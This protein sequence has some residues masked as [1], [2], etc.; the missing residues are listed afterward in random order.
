MKQHSN[1]TY[2][3]QFTDAHSDLTLLSKE[4]LICLISRYHHMY[5]K[6]SNT[7]IDESQYYLTPAEAL[8][9]IRRHLFIPDIWN[10]D[11]LKI[12]LDYEMG[13]ITREEYR[14]LMG[15]NDE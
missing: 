8:A 1:S 12:G 9:R 6:I 7:C 10:I 14:T 13:K 2:S 11:D 4:Q 15:W 3:Q 5:E